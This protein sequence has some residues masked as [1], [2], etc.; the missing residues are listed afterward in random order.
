MQKIH[1]TDDVVRSLPFT[2]LGGRRVHIADA[3]VENMRLVV[4]GDRKAFYF[5][6]DKP[7]ISGILR[8]GKYPETTTET[9]REVAS[10][11]K[12]AVTRS[13]VIAKPPEQLERSAAS[14]TF[15]AVLED[16]IEQIHLRR[17][18]RS[19][20]QDIRFLR[21]YFL[22]PSANPFALKPIG[23]VT[24][25]DVFDLVMS[26]RDR[27]ALARKRLSKIKTLFNWVMLHHRQAEFGL[28][29][30]PVSD[31]TPRMLDL[32]ARWRDRHFSELEMWAYL[33]AADRLEKASQRVFCQ[34]LVL[35]GQ[36]AGDLALMQWSELNLEEGVWIRP[37]GAAGSTPLS[38]A[39]VSLLRNLRC[40]AA[41]SEDPAVFG[42]DFTSPG[43]LTRLRCVVDRRMSDHMQ[44]TGLERPRE[45]WRWTDVRRSVLNMLV[46]ADVSYEIARCAIGFAPD[47]YT[48]M[49]AFRSTR[50]PLQRLARAL[51]DMRRS[52]ERSVTAAP[53]ADG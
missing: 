51:D 3:T 29:A 10:R 42:S 22:D 6:P 49:T 4:G 25:T 5:V 13:S 23:L 16:Y 24:A 26:T 19:A 39:T 11:L 35:T 47:R 2:A 14:W 44:G 9:A 27:P 34:I 8:I 46:E 17:H 18:N 33:A 31:L 12:G 15:A 30:N 36:P 32:R 20:A 37:R 41:A 28:A 45:P 7:G 40:S 1:L 48:A 21:R 52:V 50:D 43:K 53:A 38:N